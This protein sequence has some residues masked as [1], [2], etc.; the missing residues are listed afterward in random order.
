[1]PRWAGRTCI[2]AAHAYIDVCRCMY[3]YTHTNRHT[4]TYV[5]VWGAG[6]G[7]GGGCD[8]SPDLNPKQN[9]PQ[10]NVYVHCIYIHLLIFLTVTPTFMGMHTDMYA[11]IC[12]YIHTNRYT[13]VCVYACACVSVCVCV[14][15]DRYV[16]CVCM[17]MC[18]YPT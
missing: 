9:H 13:H 4:H 3:I 5:C 2:H 7:G 16:T 18:V 14:C 11:Y 12:I 6:R 10:K 8:T 15:I 17:N 1:M